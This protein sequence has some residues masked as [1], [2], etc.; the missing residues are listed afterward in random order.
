L[1][2]GKRKGKKLRNHVLQFVFLRFTGFRFPFAHFIS[3]QIQGYDLH[4]LFWDAVDKLQMSYTS[5]NG[6][7]N[8]RAF[9]TINVV[10][11]TRRIVSNPCNFEEK[12]AFLMDYSHVMKKV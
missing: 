10:D 5:M 12:V 3:D 11:K 2:A 9:M 7:A 6:A 1:R 4:V 8:N